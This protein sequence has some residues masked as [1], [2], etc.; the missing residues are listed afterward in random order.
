MPITEAAPAAAEADRP[1][2]EGL[3]PPA[4]ILLVF[5][6]VVIAIG[7]FAFIGGQQNALNA[8]RGDADAMREASSVLARTDASAARVIGGDR[9]GTPEFFRNL[10]R[11]KAIR[12]ATFDR[13]GGVTPA[14]D[15]LIEWVAREG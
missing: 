7:G 15:A 12:G 2:R 3:L 8:L 13:I 4:I 11:L 1:H 10:E 9:N 14:L 5:A 6:M